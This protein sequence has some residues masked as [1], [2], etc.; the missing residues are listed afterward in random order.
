AGTGQETAA[1]VATEIMALRAKTAADVGKDVGTIATAGKKRIPQCR[2][3]GA[4]AGPLPAAVELACGPI[5]TGDGIAAD[6]R[7]PHHGRGIAIGDG[8]AGDAA[9]R[10]RTAAGVAA[11]GTVADG[12]RPAIGNATGRR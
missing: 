12:Q 2:G 6:G 9:R 10:L 1:A 11:D 5:R 4:C 3:G 7:V 8:I